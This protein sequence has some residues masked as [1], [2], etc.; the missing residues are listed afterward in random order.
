MEECRALDSYSKEDLAGLA[1]QIHD[2]EITTS[3]MMPLKEMISTFRVTRNL[4]LNSFVSLGAYVLYNW[5][6]DPDFDRGFRFFDKKNWDIVKEEL[7]R[8]EEN[9]Q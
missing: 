5:N 6:D 3:Y 9:D 8:L 7:D 2:G 4:S 1:R